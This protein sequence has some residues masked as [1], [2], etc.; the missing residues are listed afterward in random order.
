MMTCIL[1]TCSHHSLSFPYYMAQDA[2]GSCCTFST[3]TLKLD[4]VPRSYLFFKCKL[5]ITSQDVG[6][7]CSSCY[8]S[9]L[10]QAPSMDRAR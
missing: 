5:I 6:A 1:V 8:C 10:F 4:I 3:Q 2:P 7:K 9:D